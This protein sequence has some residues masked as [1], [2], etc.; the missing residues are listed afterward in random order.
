MNKLKKYNNCKKCC[1]CDCC[2][3]EGICYQWVLFI[4][5]LQN[6]KSYKSNGVKPYAHFDRRVSL[7]MN[8]V[9][10][11]VLNLENIVKHGFYPFI[12]F[13]KRNTRYGKN[14]KVKY[15]N[16][17]YCSHMDRCVY[18]RYAFLINYYYNIWAQNNNIDNVAIAYRNNKDKS[19]IEF[20][21]DAFDYISGF[22]KS[23]VFVGDFT[24]FFDKINHSYLKQKLCNVLSVER[25]PNDYF[26]IFRNITCFSSL[27]WEKIIIATNEKKRKGIRKKL[28]SRA[29]LLSK[30]EFQKNKKDIYKN[31]TG[32]GIPQGS[33]ISAVLSN[34]YMVDFDKK[35]KSYVEKFNGMYM[36]YSD[37]FIIVLP[38]K[39][40][41]EVEQYKKY[42]IASIREMNDVVDLQEEKTACYLYSNNSIYS[43]PNNELSQID[44]LGFIFDGDKIKLRPR[45]ITKYYY[46]MRRKAHNI[47]KRN[48]ISP[49]GKYITAKK[50]YDIYSDNDKQ[51]T[52]ITYAKRAKRIVGL[53]DLET[54]ALIKRHKQKIAKAIKG[55]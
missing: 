44:Y 37:D 25:L 10:E 5:K 49:N 32:K 41:D 39:D 9:R 16:L 40:K 28:N 26:A 55:L 24:D 18:Q 12:H 17:Y 30:K 2:D 7:L 3:S 14:G 23:F 11:Y 47:F 43:Y 52:F 48:R 4:N 21:K 51:Q 19:N 8:N 1:E 27:D 53:K 42:I 29:I 38:Y 54:D 34:V 33:P 46:R 50:L 36:R 6:R 15:R 13:Q 45:S 20:S 22:D 31:T 35:F